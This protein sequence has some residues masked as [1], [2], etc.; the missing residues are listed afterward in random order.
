ML[1]WD[2][3]DGSGRGLVSDV[4]IVIHTAAIVSVCSHN[5]QFVAA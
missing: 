5:M 1:I 4:K 3:A 2:D